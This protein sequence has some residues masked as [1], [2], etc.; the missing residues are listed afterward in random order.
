MYS[1]A[2]VPPPHHVFSSGLKVFV[3]LFHEISDKFFMVTDNTGIFVFV[4]T[5]LM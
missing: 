2:L 4:T 3:F 5:L 1:S